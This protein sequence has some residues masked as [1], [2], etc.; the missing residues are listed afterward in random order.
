MGRAVR[1]RRWGWSDGFALMSLHS[2]G[3]NG[4]GLIGVLGAWMDGVGGIYHL[5]HND[6]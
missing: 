2:V 6:A 5:R 4:M 1:M 3:S